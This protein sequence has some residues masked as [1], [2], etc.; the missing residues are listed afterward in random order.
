MAVLSTVEAERHFP[1]P[2][3]DP[4]HRCEKPLV[5]RILFSP[6]LARLTPTGSQSH[7]GWPMLPNLSTM[8]ELCCPDCRKPLVIQPLPD[9]HAKFIGCGR[10][11]R[12]SWDV[13]DGCIA[14]GVEG[15]LMFIYA[16]KLKVI[17]TLVA[18]GQVTNT[19]ALLSQ[20]TYWRPLPISG[21]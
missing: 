1:P 9:N 10:G 5:N 21:W 2:K 16:P 6:R 19:H 12:E 13:L 11:C 4:R 20:P 17:L 7:R 8:E 14:F 3:L 18:F 15:G